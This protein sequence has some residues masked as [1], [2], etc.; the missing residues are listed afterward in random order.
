MDWST[1]FLSAGVSALV[2]TL[3]SLSAVHQTTVRKARAERA[4]A[5]RLAVR[6]LVAPILGELRRY[7]YVSPAEPA[8]T[9]N[10]I[11]SED[12]VRVSSILQTASNLPPWR[13]RLVERRCRRVFGE[14][15]T[16][17]AIEY[18]GG[19]ANDANPM[20]AWIVRS[21][22]DQDGFATTTERGPLK[23]LM[24]RAYSERAGHPLLADLRRELRRL[25]ACR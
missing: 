16:D 8:R 5:A 1:V 12:H 13:R 9:P 18:P 14:Y 4:D 22:K 7:E 2:G 24:Q 21:A 23:A 25:A 11:H 15:W 20:T 6:D 3:V 19:G 17:L 10:R